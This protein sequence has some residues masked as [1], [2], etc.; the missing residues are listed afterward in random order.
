MIAASFDGTPS[1]GRQVFLRAVDIFHIADGLVQHESPWYG[2][3]IVSGMTSGATSGVTPNA[4][5]AASCGSDRAIAAA[6]SR[7]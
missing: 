3:G 1:A 2:D 5:R 6:L 7:C 4:R